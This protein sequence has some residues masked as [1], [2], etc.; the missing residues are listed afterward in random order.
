Y[1]VSNNTFALTRQP[2]SDYA[3]MVVENSPLYGGGF[4]TGG[5][6][7]PGPTPFASG[8]VSGDVY[9][10]VVWRDD[11]SCPAATCPGTQDYKQIV[12]A[13]TLD[14]PGNQTGERGSV[15]VAS[16]FI[17]PTDS[18]VNAPIPGGN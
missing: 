10:Y 1:R 2:P 14:T 4:V 18:A 9:R 16:D 13:V 5:V 12:V 8:D 15:E 3:T 7:V 17:D 6:V 11:L